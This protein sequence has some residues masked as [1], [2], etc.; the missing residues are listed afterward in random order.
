M[1]EA[2]VLTWFA[3]ATGVTQAKLIDAKSLVADFGPHVSQRRGHGFKSRQ[4]HKSLSGGI[5]VAGMS[6][7]VVVTGRLLC[8]NG[9]PWFLRLV[10]SKRRR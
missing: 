1:S 3:R 2:D 7:H 9:A 5:A 10:A 4:L 8:G 6:A